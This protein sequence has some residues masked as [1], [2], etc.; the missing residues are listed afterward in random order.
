MPIMTFNRPYSKPRNRKEYRAKQHT[1]REDHLRAADLHADVFPDEKHSVVIRP[2]NPR[3]LGDFQFNLRGDGDHT[4]T[5]FDGMPVTK[6]DADIFDS[7]ADDKENPLLQSVT[8]LDG[9]PVTKNEVDIFSG[10]AVEVSDAAQQPPITA[11][12]AVGSGSAATATAATLS[13][14]T[15]RG[16]SATFQPPK[17]DATNAPSS[18]DSDEEL[19]F[20]IV[21]LN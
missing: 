19:E 10:A 21:A 4:V 15:G 17:N 1:L 7:V 13:P 5:W 8:W 6:P 3:F 11:A 12:A 9:T 16:T 18:D 2:A 14:L 20:G